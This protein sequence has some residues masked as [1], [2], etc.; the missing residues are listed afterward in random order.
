MGWV[1]QSVTFGY[2]T[3]LT[4]T[5]MQNLRDNLPA[6]AGGAIFGLIMSN[7]TDTDHDIAITTGICVDAVE[8]DALSLS[9]ILTKQ[10]DVDWVAGDDAGGFPSGLTLA[11]LG[12][13]TLHVFLIKNP[14]S[15]V[16]DAGFDTSLTAT[17][18]LSDATGYTLY[19]RIGSIRID[20]SDNILG[21]SQLG[22]E[23]LWK[24]PPL[25]I[26][27]SNQSTTAVTRTLSVAIGIKVHAILN[28]VAEH[29]TLRLVYLSSLD[30]N[31]ELPSA[32]VAPL[33]TFAAKPNTIF[34]MI[35]R[36]NTSGQIRSRSTGA[37]TV[38]KIAT[39]GY[40][41]RRGKDN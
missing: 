29:G 11:G 35:I 14:T 4:S 2:G 22:D 36:T 41:D 39:L 33:G 3:I 21:F 23:F 10:I 13:A 18:L 12:P 15:G 38:L 32:T 9:S 31:D 1:D 8:S 37:D 27:V 19:R 40:I 34:K 16:V 20:A 17:N 5:Q 25:D 6:I 24:D 26:D 28:V 7:D 30:T